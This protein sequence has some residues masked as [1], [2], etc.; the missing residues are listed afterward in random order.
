MEL[1]ETKLRRVVSFSRVKNETSKNAQNKKMKKY[2]KTLKSQETFE[3]IC[4]QCILYQIS[5]SKENKYMTVYVQKSYN[6][7]FRIV[8]LLL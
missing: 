5:N 2:R 7:G 4:R 3:F 6:L 1:V 8:L